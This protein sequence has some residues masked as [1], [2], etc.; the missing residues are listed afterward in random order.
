MYILDVIISYLPID[1][2]ALP[3]LSEPALPACSAGEVRRV[4]PSVAALLPI[5][6]SLPG[7]EAVVSD[8]GPSS[9]EMA[10]CRAD[11]KDNH[12]KINQIILIL[13]L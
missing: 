8:M 12:G 13:I 6:S 4:D 10:F 3:P 5:S 7:A 9:I 11:C 2:M 1:S